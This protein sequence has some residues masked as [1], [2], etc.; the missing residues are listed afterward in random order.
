MISFATRNESLLEARAREP[1]NTKVQRSIERGILSKVFDHRTPKDVLLHLKDLNNNYHRGA[2]TSHVEL[3]AR[4]EEIEKAWVAHKRQLGIR[5]RHLPTKG[6]NTYH[7]VFGKWF[8]DTYPGIKVD[9]IYI[10]MSIHIFK[11]A[12]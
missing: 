10:Y 9:Y 6:D 3:L 2:G 12:C 4:I 7:K 1:H 5:A 11:C 8:K